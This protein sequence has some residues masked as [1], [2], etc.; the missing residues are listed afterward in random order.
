MF[1]RLTSVFAG[2]RGRFL[3]GRRAT[4]VITASYVP[5]SASGVTAGGPTRALAFATSAA[6]AP[7]LVRAAGR[8]GGGVDVPAVSRRPA[9]AGRRS[10]T[11]AAGARPPR[12]GGER[13]ERTDYRPRGGDDDRGGPRQGFAERVRNLVSAVRALDEA[14]LDPSSI[15]IAARGAL[16]NLAP[17]MRVH[18]YGTALRTLAR[19]HND[20]TRAGAMAGAAGA[21]RLPPAHFFFAPLVE[22]L[23]LRGGG[24]SD[25]AWRAWHHKYL[26]TRDSDSRANLQYWRTVAVA[27][28]MRGEVEEGRAAVAR[29]FEEERLPASPRELDWELAHQALRAAMHSAR[30][31]AEAVAWRSGGEGGAG[32]ADPAALVAVFVAAAQRSGRPGADPARALFRGAPPPPPPE[33][34]P[35][36]LL[37]ATTVGL[38]AGLEG[39]GLAVR[40]RVLAFQALARG[41]EAEGALH[42]ARFLAEHPAPA[43]A[44]TRPPPSASRPPAPSASPPSTAPS[45]SPPASATRSSPRPAPPCCGPRPSPHPGGR[46]P[47]WAPERTAGL[48]ETARALLHCGHPAEAERIARSQLRAVVNTCR[49]ALDEAAFAGALARLQLFKTASLGELWQLAHAAAASADQRARAADLDALVTEHQAAHGGFSP[50]TAAALRLVSTAPAMYRP[51]QVLEA[52]ETLLQRG[53][54]GVGAAGRH[55]RRLRAPRPRPAR[56]LDRVPM[57]FKFA[58]ACRAAGVAVPLAAVREVVRGYFRVGDL[59]AAEDAAEELAAPPPRPAPHPDADRERERGERE[60]QA[61]MRRRPTKERALAWEEHLL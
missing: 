28:L 49:L 2:G 37:V 51:G 33:A 36:A 32:V 8:V 52:C 9:S 60:E 40:A 13:A 18:V 42:A 41:A 57:A 16:A 21:L 5:P 43:P 30:I 55:G 10:V 6:V 12:R 61:A 27:H 46:A 29:G 17:G 14:R 48:L 38:A 47:E 15:V 31:A 7:A 56:G 58:R 54:G 20:T 44:P 59:R 1:G 34:R 39:A 50:V 11:H 4:C 3:G 19:E 25:A 53:G 23:S 22:V 26:A 35:A 45:P 24:A